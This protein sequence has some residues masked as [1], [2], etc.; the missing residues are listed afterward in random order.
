MLMSFLAGLYVGW[1][2]GVWYSAWVTSL[3]EKPQAEPRILREALDIA[4][5][6]D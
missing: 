4:E 5:R 2:S 1:L 3:Y 6:K